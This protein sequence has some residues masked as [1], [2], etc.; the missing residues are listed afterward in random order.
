MQ[1]SGIKLNDLL[2]TCEAENL[3]DNIGIENI[4]GE[5]TIT[6]NDAAGTCE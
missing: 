2:P 3:R 1:N 6:G 5:I 4:G